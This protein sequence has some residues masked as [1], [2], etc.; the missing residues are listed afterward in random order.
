MNINFKYGRRYVTFWSEDLDFQR[1]IENLCVVLRQESDFL[2]VPADLISI[3]I[4]IDPDLHVGIDQ[5]RDH[6]LSIDVFCNEG[7]VT[8]SHGLRTIESRGI[9]EL[10]SWNADHLQT[11]VGQILTRTAN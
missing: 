3:L 1:V 7:F 4:K 10:T 6:G 5:R 2:Q 9:E 8:V 11:F